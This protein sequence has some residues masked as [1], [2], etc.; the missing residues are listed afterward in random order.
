MEFLS[1]IVDVLFYIW[2]VR[3]DTYISQLTLYTLSKVSTP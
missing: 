1:Q 2:F 3:R